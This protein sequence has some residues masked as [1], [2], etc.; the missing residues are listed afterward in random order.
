VVRGIAR[1]LIATV[2]ALCATS[3]CLT[4]PAVLQVENV[5]AEKARARFP[6]GTQAIEVEVGKGRHLRGLFVP[7]ADPKAPLVLHLLE[8]GGSVAS[9]DLDYALLAAQLADLGLASLFVDYTG[10]GAS[11][12]EP[13]PEH[14]RRDARA[15]FDEAVRRAGGDPEHVLVRAISL[16]TVA[17]GELLESGARPGGLELLEPV[18]GRDVVDRFA[19]VFYGRV[20]SWITPLIFHGV[21]QLDL[22]ALARTWDGLPILMLTPAEEALADHT[23]VENLRLV[24]GIRGG[25]AKVVPGNHFLLGIR[26]HELVLPEEL[27]F[28]IHSFPAGPRPTAAELLRLR[29]HWCLEGI[30]PQDATLRAALEQ[31]D[32]PAGTI[33]IDMLEKLTFPLRQ[34]H[35]FNVFTFDFDAADIQDLARRRG[36]TRMAWWKFTLHLSN[37]LSFELSTDLPAVFDELVARGFVGI[38][39]RRIFARLLLK[40]YGIPDRVNRS[41]AG[42]PALEAFVKGEW[43]NIDLSEPEPDEPAPPVTISGK[44]PARQ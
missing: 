9:V 12:G 31:L 41:A 38:D 25:S 28:L 21:T 19:L 34:T 3:A 43:I 22:A 35:R 6:A 40:A 10:I 20:A 30:A 42:E 16:G 44:L 37:G 36:R 27:E 32:D 18:D 1:S 13:S 2:F 17:A 11:D 23:W 4:P 14:L 5:D 26:C 29:A 7:A 39:A 15:A 24:I 33:P 8:S